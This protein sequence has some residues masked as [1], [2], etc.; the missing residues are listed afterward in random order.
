MVGAVHTAFEYGRMVATAEYN[1]APSSVALFFMV[2]HLAVSMLLL[3][4]AVF[5]PRRKRANEP[6]DTRSPR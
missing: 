3:V 4:A 6:A 5:T 2:P 1:S